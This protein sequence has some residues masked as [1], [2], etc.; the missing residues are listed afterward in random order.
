[1]NDRSDATGP[2]AFRRRRFRPV[3]KDIGSAGRRLSPAVPTSTHV[4]AEIDTRDARR[5]TAA[6]AASDRFNI[7]EITPT[8][9]RQYYRRIHR[10]ATLFCSTLPAEQ[11]QQQLATAQCCYGVMDQS[12][13]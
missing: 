4:T 8:Y 5:V 13:K 1:V 6:L 2:S 3:A 9:Y 10:S 7:D 12:P 11:Q